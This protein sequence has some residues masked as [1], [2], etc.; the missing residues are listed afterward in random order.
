M[1]TVLPVFPVA[2]VPATLA[3]Y[4]ETLGFSERMRMPM[5]D[6]SV[7]TGRTGRGGVDLMFNL[8]PA[9]AP[10]SGGGVWCWLYLDG[11]AVDALWTE[12]SAKGVEV[13]EPIKDQFWGDRSF[14]IKDCNGFVL[15]FT[16]VTDAAHKASY[17]QD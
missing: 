14:A 8:N 1:A 10:A 2:D 16:Q 5:P 6:G 9:D 12:F 11:E 7:V 4:Q 15:V 13:V 3:W 17:D